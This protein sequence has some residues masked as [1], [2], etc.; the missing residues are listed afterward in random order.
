MRKDLKTWNFSVKHPD[1][2]GGPALLQTA[3][4][5]GKEALKPVI[6]L[7]GSCSSP[8]RAAKA[9]SGQ[10]RLSFKL[11][12]F[13]SCLVLGCLKRFSLVE[14]CSGPGLDSFRMSRSIPFEPCSVQ[15]V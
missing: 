10:N 1:I 5:G 14:S 11:F 12:F 4:A 15:K 6:S 13:S 9:T 7:L 3:L 2:G 8:A